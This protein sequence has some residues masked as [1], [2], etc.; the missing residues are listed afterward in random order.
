MKPFAI[1]I[2]VILIAVAC[3]AQKKPSIAFEATVARI[4]PW[5]LV[6]ISCG[7][8]INY[9]LAEYTIGTVYSGKLVRGQVLPVKHLACNYNELE[10]L[11]VGDKVLVVA[12]VLDTPDKVN[13][14][15]YP[16][17]N[18]TSQD[19]TLTISHRALSV[20]K[21]VYPTADWPR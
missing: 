6:K 20:G 3:N 10:N 19:K 17:S 5:G 9:R 21:L 11:K 14:K 1:I 13:W 8:A 4:E 18:A 12:E 2:A 16:N 15:Q 7:I